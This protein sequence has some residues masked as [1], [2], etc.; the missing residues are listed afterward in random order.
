VKVDLSLSSHQNP[1]AIVDWNS[2]EN[3]RVCKSPWTI[4]CLE[5]S[6][7]STVRA[8]PCSNRKSW[9]LKNPMQFKLSYF[10]PVSQFQVFEFCTVWCCCTIWL[11]RT[12]FK[13]LLWFLHSDITDWPNMCLTK[14]I[15]SFFYTQV[16]DSFHLNSIN[17]SNNSVFLARPS[18][19]WHAPRV[20]F[21]RS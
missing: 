14:L 4:S 8:H 13:I 19:Q 18:F 7:Y 11:S 20:W 10:E 16:I 12:S 9:R 1:T 17:S 2:N 6:Q 3:V 21:G 5:Y 15:F